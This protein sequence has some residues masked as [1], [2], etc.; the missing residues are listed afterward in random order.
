MTWRSVAG[1]G[2]PVTGAFGFSVA[3]PLEEPTEQPT[4]RATDE[5]TDEPTEQPTTSSVTPERP[6]PDREAPAAW[7]WGAAVGVVALAGLGALGLR[8]R[9]AHD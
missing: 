9:G 7:V 1:D 3:A 4:E 8:R 6:G 2:H 5:P